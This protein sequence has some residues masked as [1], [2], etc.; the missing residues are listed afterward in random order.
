MEAVFANKHRQHSTAHSMRQNWL[1]TDN[2]IKGCYGAYFSLKTASL[3]AR[4]LEADG[5]GKNPTFESF[6]PMDDVIEKLV[7]GKLVKVEGMII[8][9]LSTA[10]QKL[11]VRVPE[12]P[13]T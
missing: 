7:Y 10:S 9:H 3:V 1:K 4:Y 8:S 12:K 13:K 11:L 6:M 2:F 5:T